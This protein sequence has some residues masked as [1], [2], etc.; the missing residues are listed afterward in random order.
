MVPDMNTP[1]PL[2]LALINRPARGGVCPGQQYAGRLVGVCRLGRAANLSGPEVAY[3]PRRSPGCDPRRFMA[4]RVVIRRLSSV[5][6]FPPYASSG[7]VLSCLT[8]RLHSIP[9]PRPVAEGPPV[10]VMPA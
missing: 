9:V 10:S 2:V 4:P 6:G 5:Q 3:A 1:R 8:Y 7:P